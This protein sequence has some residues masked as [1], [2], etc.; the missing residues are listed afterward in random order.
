MKSHSLNN[1]ISQIKHDTETLE[2]LRYELTV[3]VDGTLIFFI[4]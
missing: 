1:P 3:D 4:L 2:M